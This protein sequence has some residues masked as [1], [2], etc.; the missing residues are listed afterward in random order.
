[1]TKQIGITGRYGHL[2]SILAES[3][4]PIGNPV[5]LRSD[6]QH[7]E[8]LKDEAKTLGIDML[9][10]CAAIVGT[11]AC[12]RAGA[13]A[14]FNVNSTGAENAAEVAASLGVPFVFMS[15]CSIYD[16]HGDLPYE[17]DREEHIAPATLYGESKLQAEKRIADVWGGQELV[18]RPSFVYGRHPADVSLLSQLSRAAA[19]DRAVVLDMDMRRKKSYLHHTDF[20]AAVVGLIEA[21]E[22]GTFNVVSDNYHPWS[23]FKT[24]LQI[25]NRWPRYVIYRPELD[26]KGDHIVSSEKLRAALPWWK[27]HVRIEDGVAEL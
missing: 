17:E 6:V 2:G 22:T 23:D 8:S 5:P 7:Y 13:T 1:M 20:A 4:A 3:L 18:I 25:E 26:Y 27:E 21:G 15:S 9:I 10:H 19:T 24:L 12:E 14:T 16:P 11:A